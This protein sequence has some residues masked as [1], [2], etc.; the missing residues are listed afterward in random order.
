MAYTPPQINTEMLLSGHYKTGIS[1]QIYHQIGSF[2][3]VAERKSTFAG[4][5]CYYFLK[6][7]CYALETYRRDFLLSQLWVQKPKTISRC[8][9]TYYKVEPIVVG[10]KEVSKS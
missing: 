9:S 4:L 8:A 7:V 10:V 5:I 6:G 1:R 3:L 2:H